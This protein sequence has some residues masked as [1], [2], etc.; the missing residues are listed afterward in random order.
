MEIEV[1][2][3][4][5]IAEIVGENKL[6]FSSVSN[7]DELTSSLMEKYP[8]LQKINFQIAC[9]NQLINENQALANNDVL[10]FLPPFAGG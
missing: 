10:A 8:K 5:E 4:G 2:F 1:L 6:I 3:F 9:N 7:S